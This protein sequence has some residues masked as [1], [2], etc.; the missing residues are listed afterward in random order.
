MPVAIIATFLLL[1]LW[2]A[3]EDLTGVPTVAHTSLSHWCL[4]ATWLLLAPVAAGGAHRTARARPTPPRRPVD[5]AQRAPNSASARWN[6]TQL[7]AMTLS[8]PS[9]RLPRW[10]WVNAAGAISSE[11]VFGDTLRRW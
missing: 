9:G 4:A 2:R 1:P 7:V 5:P 6:S 11:P 3:F 10:V 8:P